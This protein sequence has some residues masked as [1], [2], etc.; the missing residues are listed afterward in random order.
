MLAIAR[1]TLAALV[2]VACGADPAPEPDYFIDGVGIKVE[3]GASDWTQAADF[4]ARVRTVAAVTMSYGG[5]SWDDLRGWVIV[6]R[7]RRATID[8]SKTSTPGAETN[9]CTHDSGWMEIST[10]TLSVESSS[11]V[12]EVLHAAIGDGCHQDGRWRDF[13]P[14]MGALIESGALDGQSYPLE[15]WPF[16]WIRSPTC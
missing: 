10:F 15:L 11:L 1:L 2:L 4:R 6:F 13:Q 12:H 3:P 5:K 14:V 8:C 9:G 16:L 7:E